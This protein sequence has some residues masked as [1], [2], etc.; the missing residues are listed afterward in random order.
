MIHNI[1]TGNYSKDVEANILSIA[2][3]L[4]NSRKYE[5]IRNIINDNKNITHVAG[6]S[7]GGAWLIKRAQRQNGETG[8]RPKQTGPPTRNRLYRYY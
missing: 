1:K 5:N 7:L 4:Q 2:A 6:Y 3:R 8:K